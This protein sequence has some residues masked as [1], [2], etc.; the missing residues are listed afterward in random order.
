M[1]AIKSL[2]DIRGFL[3]YFYPVSN[4][5]GKDK[6]MEAYA[7]IETGGKQ[8][9]VSKDDMV[10]IEKLD[11]KPGEKVAV[12]VL[13][14]SDGKK[15][16]VGTPEL[17]DAKVTLEIAKTYKGEKVVSFKKKRRKGFT[18]KIGHRQ[19]IT[20]AKVIALS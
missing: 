17:K 4:Q 10:K 12:K 18:K 11:V 20:L 15:L 16:K 7:V 1:Q 9:P 3:P 2:L 19:H 8:Y 13:A 6:T 14:I 5:K